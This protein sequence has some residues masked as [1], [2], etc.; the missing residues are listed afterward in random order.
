MTIAQ[1]MSVMATPTEGKIGK[2]SVA[3]VEGIRGQRK[4]WKA[5]WVE[6]EVARYG[7]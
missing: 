1:I 3:Q 5:N 2:K 7:S 6:Q 4:Q